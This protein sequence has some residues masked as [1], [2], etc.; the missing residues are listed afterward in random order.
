MNP[1]PL[2]IFIFLGHS[3][4]NSGCASI[5]VDTTYGKYGKFPALYLRQMSI[6]YP[7]RS[8]SAICCNHLSQKVSD[9]KRGEARYN[10]LMAAISAARDTAIIGGVIMAFGFI[11][12]KDSAEAYS[13][14]NDL[15]LLL[16]SIRME[17]QNDSLSCIIFRY[18]KNN[19]GLSNVAQYSAYSDVIDR[20]IN[21]MRTYRNVA[22]APVRY[23]PK[24]YYCENHHSNRDGYAILSQD[25]A[26]LYQINGFDFW[27]S[28]VE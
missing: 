2:I 22:L 13:F 27:N 18:E 4:M 6:R 17:A 9:I 3:N 1:L 15:V 24:R 26:V 7:E 21:S 20:E 12:G 16:E 5:D 10:N 11:E 14:R 25:M 8:F 19:Q 28:G 23:L